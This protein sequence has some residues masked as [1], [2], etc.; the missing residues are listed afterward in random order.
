LSSTPSQLGLKLDGI[1]QKLRQCCPKRIVA[2]ATT[3]SNQSRSTSLDD[4]SRVVQLQRK[5][6]AGDGPTLR[7][8]EDADEIILGRPSSDQVGLAMQGAKARVSESL[9]SGNLE[10]VAEVRETALLQLEGQLLLFNVCA[11]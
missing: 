2:A 7:I 10:C 1:P 6:P 3:D 4:F 8:S 5:S 9:T 11:A